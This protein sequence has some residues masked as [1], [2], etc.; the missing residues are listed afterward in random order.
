MLVTPLH[1]SELVR[2]V[3]PRPPLRLGKKKKKQLDVPSYTLPLAASAWWG[4]GGPTYTF[5]RI[6]AMVDQ[7][8]ALHTYTNAWP[9]IARCAS[10]AACVFIY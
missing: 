7:G 10:A 8:L 3:G 5:V 9:L 2:V 6:V 1:E 4:G